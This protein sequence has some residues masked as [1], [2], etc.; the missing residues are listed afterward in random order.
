MSEFV[1]DRLQTSLGTAYT[2]E[3]ELGGGGMSRVFV[4]EEHA[5][6]RKIVVKVLPDEIAETVSQERF[7]REIQLLGALQHPNIVPILRAGDAGD[8]PYYIMSFVEGASLRSA[9][10]ERGRLGIAES[11]RILRD[12]ASALAYAHARNIIHR[13]IKPENVLLNGGAAVVTDFG[14]AKA[15]R[16][17]TASDRTGERTETITSI[18]LSVGTPA[19]MSP[20]QVL[21]DPTLDHRSDIYSLGC[22][23][24]EILVGQPPFRALQM[25]QLLAQHV[26]AAPRDLTSVRPD[27]PASLNALL[28]QCL[29]KDPEARPQ[30]AAEIVRRLDEMMSPLSTSDQRDRHRPRMAV[31]GGL[32]LALALTVILAVRS[33]SSARATSTPA[34]AQTIAVL[35][36]TS[37]GGDSSSQWMAEGTTEELTAAL[38]KLSGV[39]VIP[40]TSASAAVAKVGRDPEAVARLLGVAALL[41]GSLRRTSR[42]LRLTMRLL[43]GTDGAMIWSQEFSGPL[44]STADIFD[45]QSE[46]ARKVADALRVGLEPSAREPR[47]NVGLI[48]HDLYLRGRYFAARYTEA[49]LRRAIQLYD[50]ALALE[51]RYALALAANAEAWSYL[52]DTW[53]APREAYPRANA[54]VQEAL[55]ID[56]T[57]AHAWG[58]LANIGAIYYWNHALAEQ[59]VQRT[60]ERDST[61]SAALLAI[62][63]ETMTTNLDSA[64]AL[65][66]TG[67]RLDQLNPLFSFWASATD[68]ALGRSDE[69]CR[70]AAR[71]AEMAPGTAQEW[72]IAECFIARRQYDSAAAHL[73]VPA[74]TSTQQRALYARA[75]ALAG[76]RAEARTELV[77]LESE[78]TRRYVSGATMAAAYGALGDFDAAFR[79]L[80]RAV[81]DRAA[82]LAILSLRP[83]LQALESDPR[84]RAAL[85]RMRPLEPA[86]R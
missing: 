11:V 47:L 79:S 45:I 31:L 22:L 77:A 76:R 19:Y 65:L 68:F 57:L 40:P 86:P 42:E 60:R 26:Q 82:E 14:I 84:Y 66:E 73:R 18:G 39:R 10:L 75:L 35:P 17:A 20:E 7:R 81:D 21:A 5:L 78:R 36:L 32:A 25:P 67:E 37:V 69:G 61:S 33:H 71:G 29:A 28:M 9:L 24:Y 41:E 80:E 59:A 49:D 16:N 70:E 50:S 3:R 56:S 4:A 58:V 27:V 55:S 13:D 8:T 1:R 62:A 6:H 34:A 15:L 44:V 72:M 30:S 54:A 46:I 51:P 64:R 12:I 23:G 43:N 53:V 52:A 2:L 83:M 63:S 74:Q 48:P 38:G 85:S